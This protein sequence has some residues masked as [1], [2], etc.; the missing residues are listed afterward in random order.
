MDD[1]D[2]KKTTKDRR[3]GHRKRLRER[4]ERGGLVALNDYEVVEL[5]LTLGQPRGDLKDQ[6]KDALDRFKNLRGVLD[7]TPE[8]L[9]E[10]DGIG[11]VSATMLRFVREVGAEY[12]KQRAIKGPA[13]GS[14][15]AALDYLCNSMGGLKKEAFRVLFLNSQ[16]EL[17]EAK[18]I[19]KGTVNASPVFAR[20]VIQEALGQH[21][22]A[23]IFAHNHPSGSTAPSQDDKSVTRELVLAANVMGLRVLDH[24]IIGDR[25]HYSFAA[26]GLI[27]RYEA[28]AEAIKRKSA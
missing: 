22:T 2:S 15:K 21:A 14:E 10:I 16:N 8:Q 3:E 23:L 18:D 5:L 4:Y 11:D 6:A 7:A 12:M 24:L 20:D 13:M 17:L 25:A 9:A 28:E 19:S 27:S 1:A 26:D